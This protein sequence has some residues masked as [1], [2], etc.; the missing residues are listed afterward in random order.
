LEKLTESHGVTIEWRSFELR[1]KS[2]PPISEEYKARILANRPRMKQMAWEMYGLQINEG[3]FGIDSRPVLVGA[4]YAEAQGHGPAYHERVLRAYWEEAENLEDIATL[5]RLAA[6]AGLD[7]DAFEAAL[8][9]K[10]YDHQV[11]R[12]V[13]TAYQSGINGVPALIFDGKYFVSG[14][15]PYEVLADVVEQIESGEMARKYG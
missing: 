9:E 6:D 10:D 15:Q 2:G 14:A 4:K 12:D 1:P 3:P 11:T 13:L 8:S 5:K 7:P